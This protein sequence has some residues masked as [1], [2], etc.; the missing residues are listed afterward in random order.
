MRAVRLPVVVAA[1]LLTVVVGAGASSAESTTDAA[2][3]E[4]RELRPA[5]DAA[6]VQGKRANPRSRTIAVGPRRAAMQFDLR[7]VTKR[8]TRARLLLRVR[9][10]RRGL[11]VARARVGTKGRIARTRDRGVRGTVGRDGR[12]TFD[13]TRRVRSG[14]RATLLLYRRTRG[15]S[16]V[17]SRQ[18]GRS[19]G[20]RLVLDLPGR[21]PS[22]PPTP[23]VVVTPVPPPAP[24]PPPP[25]PPPPSPVIVAA[26]DIADNDPNPGDDITARLIDNLNPTAV[27][28]LGDLAYDNGTLTEFQTWYDPTWGR[29]K[30]R[31]YPV[32]GNHEY[33]TPGAA[34]YFD[35]FNGVGA[36]FGVA[37]SRTDGWYSFDLGNWHIVALN[38]NCTAVGG[39]D[40][41]SR[42][43]AWLRADLAAST[44]PC[45]LAYWHH[46]RFAANMATEAV[47]GFWQALYDANAEIVLNAHDR[48]YQ[49]F[50]PLDAAGRP[51]PLRGIREFVVG[52]G[53]KGHHVFNS[54]PSTVEAAH[55]GS[56][57]VLRLTLHPSSYEWAFVPQGGSVFTTESGSGT[58]H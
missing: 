15:R 8:V 43:V 37:G 9:G 22:Q 30:A 1:A 35:Y 27:L 48:N 3:L 18:N 32:P 13:V 47:A 16:L 10:S 19:L 20:P 24:A 55:T 31:T 53:G 56:F 42:Q 29:H 36:A 51:D 6:L 38:S 34:G 4:R 11:W 5:W 46:P 54:S 17:A 21:A 25:P 52:T 49:R 23:P 44:R 28:P 33:G 41:T 2:V 7:R 12:V 45:T 40:A 50:A 26:G 14:E 39:C 58:C 57:G